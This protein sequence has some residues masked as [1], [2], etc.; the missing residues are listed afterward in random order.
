MDSV[1]R[2]N[3]KRCRLEKC[4]TIGMKPGKVDMVDRKRGRVKDTAVMSAEGNFVVD[5]VEYVE[6]VKVMVSGASTSVIGGNSRNASNDSP[7]SDSS[8]SE[9]SES[10]NILDIGN[11]VEECVVEEKLHTNLVT[12]N[13]SNAAV[14]NKFTPKSVFDLALKDADA[15]DPA[16]PETT[17]YNEPDFAFTLEE[18]FKIYELVVRK[19]YLVD[20]IL[21]LVFEIPQFKMSILDF[22]SSGKFG[23]NGTTARREVRR[24]RHQTLR[25]VF[26]FNLNP[27][28]KI[29][30]CLDM[31]DEYKNVDENVKY[32]TF[33]FS[34]KVLHICNR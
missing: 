31:F 19:D 16:F 21:G 5:E 20:V 29:R 17:L 3:C 27:G 4:L 9:S 11:L 6:E 18:E 24:E 26:G 13:Q 8:P 28:G 22:L 14:H 25:N 12:Y 15:V 7:S 2:T 10:S 1:T 30:A 23:C 33:D 32:E 34:L